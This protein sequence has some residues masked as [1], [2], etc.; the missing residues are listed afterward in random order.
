VP[1]AARA[2]A[3]R[4]ACRGG[5]TLARHFYIP[6]IMAGNSAQRSGEIRQAENGAGFAR[7]FPLQPLSKTQIYRAASA[8]RGG[9]PVA[10]GRGELQ[11]R[12][13]YRDRIKKGPGQVGSQ[14]DPGKALRAA[15]PGE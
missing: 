12:C 10:G 2:C 6:V 15:R 5:T 8:S 13:A 9:Q 3:C 11:P 7:P 1:G 4:A 14:I